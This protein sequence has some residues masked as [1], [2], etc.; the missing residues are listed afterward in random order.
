VG[1]K[2]SSPSQEQSHWWLY[3][4]NWVMPAE[5]GGL[6]TFDTQGRDTLIHRIQ[7]VFCRE[8]APHPGA[9]GDT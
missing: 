3:L 9:T 6:P 1:T 5:D 7:R 4:V 8:S 2:T